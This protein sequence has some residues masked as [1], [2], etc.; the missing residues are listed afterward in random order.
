MRRR[1]ASTRASA[2]ETMDALAQRIPDGAY[3][4][5][6]AID[7]D[8]LT[9]IGLSNEAAAL[10]GRLEGAAQWD[11]PALAGALQQDPRTRMDRFTLMAK[12]RSDAAKEPARAA[13]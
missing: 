9:L 12:L 1:I 4:E 10:V 8:Q 6:L 7:G 3:L 5:K 11:A 13:R 2:V